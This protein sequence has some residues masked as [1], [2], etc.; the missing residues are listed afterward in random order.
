MKLI[1]IHFS[2]NNDGSEKAPEKIIEQI[3]RR[4][5]NEN[6][7]LPVFDVEN[8]EVEK[9]NSEKTQQNIT[10]A[11]AKAIEE[12]SKCLILGGDHF[13]TYYSLSA[14]LKKFSDAGLLAIDAFPNCRIGEYIRLAIKDKLIKKENI[15]MF[16]LRK[17]ESEEYSFL[18]EQRIKYYDMRE[19]EMETLHEVSESLMQASRRFNALYLSIS[20]SVVDPAFAPGVSRAEVGGLTAREIL[21]LL[22]RVSNLKNL[23]AVDLV[24]INPEKDR[25]E[26]TIKLGAKIASEMF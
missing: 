14:F 18:K 4:F 24:D 6:G 17:W 2:K 8:V 7:M 1:K 15:L 11:V 5:L 23:R 19:T 22:N 26:A 20:M 9:G 21:F 12:S 25:D 13:S 10:D 16:G 3:D